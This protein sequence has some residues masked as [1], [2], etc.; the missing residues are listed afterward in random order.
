MN[1]AYLGDNDGLTN[2]FTGPTKG[3]IGAFQWM[4]SGMNP[5]VK[6]YRFG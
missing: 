1:P 3:F 2:D 4:S 5:D 6:S